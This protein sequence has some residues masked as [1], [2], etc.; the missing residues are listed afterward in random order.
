MRLNLFVL[1]VLLV[2]GGCVHDRI[3]KQPAIDVVAVTN[4]LTLTLDSNELSTEQILKVEDFIAK[5]GNPY[6]LRVKLVSGST[7]GRDQLEK[8]HQVLLVRGISKSKIS[9]QDA[10]PS[11]Q[12]D[13]Q[14]IVESFRAKVANCG[15]SKMQPVVFNQYQSHQAY[16][17]TNAAALAQMVANPKELIVGERLGPANGEKAVAAIDAYVSPSANNSSSQNSDSSVGI[18]AGNQ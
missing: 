12:G 5:R 10:S 14:L 17:C 16:G 3:A 18:T 7:K 13:I 11:Q 4:K 1:P 9:N 2:L 15:A 6:G 8:I